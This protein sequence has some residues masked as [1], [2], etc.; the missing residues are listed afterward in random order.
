MFSLV[1]PIQKA[2]NSI[3]SVDRIIFHF[4]CT[5]LIQPLR[6]TK[7]DMARA[8]DDARKRLADVSYSPQPATPAPLRHNF[9]SHCSFCFLLLLPFFFFL[10]LLV[11]VFG[12]F[13][14]PLCVVLLLTAL[15]LFHFGERLFVAKDGVDAFVNNR[16]GLSA[17][18]YGINLETACVT[19]T[20]GSVCGCVGGCVLLVMLQLLC[21]FICVYH[22]SQHTNTVSCSVKTETTSSSFEVSYR[23][24][25]PWQLVLLHPVKECV[26]SLYI[27]DI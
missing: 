27:V 20:K 25:M 22:F 18:M 2:F 5:P 16:T 17:R 11:F 1:Q 23:H 9:A 19:G 12:F 3:I 14:F 24:F 21:R 10:C 6:K 4:V 8:M 26:K 13:C 15:P 7:S